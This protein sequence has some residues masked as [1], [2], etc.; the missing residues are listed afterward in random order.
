MQTKVVV[1]ACSHDAAKY[2]VENW[3][4]SRILPSG[5]LVKLGVWENDRFIG[6]I[7]FSRGASPYLG[8]KIDLDQTELCELT[9]VALTTHATPVSQLVAEA[10][11][12]LRQDNPG[13]RAIVSFADPKE[14]HHGGIY[15]AGNWLFTGRTNPTIEYWIGNRWRHTRGSYWHPDRKGAKT[16]EVPG[17]FRYMYP[18][19]KQTRRRLN[20]IAMPY[21]TKAEV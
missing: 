14:G 5:K 19:D 9:R 15:Q 7:I 4:Y 8:K 17:K 16:R 10:I 1:A 12:I 2:A 11:R 18:L 21:P 20:K 13:M 3:H 6:V